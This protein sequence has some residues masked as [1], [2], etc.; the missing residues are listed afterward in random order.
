MSRAGRLIGTA[1]R[2]D[3]VL[4][5]VTQH[6]SRSTVDRSYVPTKLRDRASAPTRGKSRARLEAIRVAPRRA[7]L[8]LYLPSRKAG[9]AA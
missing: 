4:I 5:P 9:V 2:E 3:V 6:Y 1:S 7:A 8:T